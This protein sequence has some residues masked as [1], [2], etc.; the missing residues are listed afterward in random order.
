VPISEVID[1]TGAGNTYCGGL[2]LGLLRGKPLKEAALMGAVSASFC[3]EHIGI[4]DPDTI[5]HSE[6]DQ[7]FRSVCS[8]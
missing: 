6:R 1:Q 7:R 3:L 4:L 5:S 2:L 8:L